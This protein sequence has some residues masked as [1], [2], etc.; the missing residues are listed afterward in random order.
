[1]EESTEKGNKE[2]ISNVTKKLGGVALIVLGLALAYYFIYLKI[3]AM[4]A[5]EQD[6]RYSIKFMIIVPFMT[7]LGFYYALFTPS[8]SG[9]WK[10]MPAK[11]KPIFVSTIITALFT[12][13]AVLFWFNHQLIANGYES[14]F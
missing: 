7:V 13:V 1:M 4:Q 9:A 14:I 12:I 10:E 5:H 6:I 3:V 8:G 11:E 2:P